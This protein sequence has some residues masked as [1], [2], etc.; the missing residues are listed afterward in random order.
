MEGTQPETNAEEATTPVTEKPP[1]ESPEQTSEAPPDQPS[2]EPPEQPPRKLLRPPPRPL[3]RPLP[4]T[5]RRNLGSL[6]LPHSPCVVDGVV[7]RNSQRVH[8][9]RRLF[10]G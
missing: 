1:E 9:R 7:L 2:E 8:W 4:E 6:S 3:P 5:E 10:G